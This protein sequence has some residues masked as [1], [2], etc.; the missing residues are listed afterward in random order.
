MSKQSTGCSGCLKYLLFIII[1]IFVCA[2]IAGLGEDDGSG[3][4]SNIGGGNGGGTTAAP[5][6]TPVGG[7]YY[8]QLTETEKTLYDGLLAEVAEGDLSCTFTDVDYDTYVEMV[9]RVV[10]AIHY[11]HPEY[12]WINGG[13]ITSG[14]YRPGS[15]RDV[16]TVDLSCYQYW[17]YTMSPD[18]YRLALE[19]KVEEIAAKAQAYTT[20]F[21]QIRYVHDY[22][23]LNTVYDYDNL[24]EAQKTH[25]VASSEYIYSAYGC[26]INGKAVCAGYAKAF[27][28]ILTK[29]GYECIYVTGDAGG[30]HAWNCVTVD[31]EDY[32]VDVTWDDKDRKN[33]QGAPAYPH[34]AEYQYFC[35]TSA[36]LSRN[37][38]A[39]TEEFTTPYCTATKYN[40]YVYNN[41]VL[42]DYS[43]AAMDAAVAA[44]K[45]RQLISVQF[46]TAAEL[47]AA[48][49]DLFGGHNWSQLPSL[50]SLPSIMYSVD[51][52]MLVLTLLL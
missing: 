19:Q 21:E 40:Y 5:A 16:M 18:K 24:E 12:F 49:A 27:Q 33:D 31:G 34:D 2:G 1:G 46:T 11:D 43:R 29:L 47:S 51:E 41:L 22:L 13:S 17:T 36:Q 8:E 14:Q 30:P 48:C 3:T 26:L 37:H 42:E 52:D 4:V 32:L 25:H 6:P 28:L 7:A 44:Q 9:P 50:Q 20:P 39:D 45:G 15:H 23:V 10:H 38:T 35:V